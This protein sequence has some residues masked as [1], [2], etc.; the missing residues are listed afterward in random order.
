LQSHTDS[1]CNPTDP[2]SS[3]HTQSYIHVK[4]YINTSRI[5]IIHQECQ[6][7]TSR[8]SRIDE[9]SEKRTKIHESHLHTAQMAPSPR[10]PGWSCL[11]RQLATPRLG[12][13]LAA[14]RRLAALRSLPRGPALPN[15]GC[16]RLLL[17]RVGEINQ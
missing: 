6:E 3:I 14:R 15:S 8:M 12:R 7:Y 10:C 9:E 4:I 5:T 17:L 1:I 11:G 2:R 13:W 16:A